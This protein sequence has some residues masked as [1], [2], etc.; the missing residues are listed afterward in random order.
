M[1]ISMAS[2]FAA[3]VMAC[4]PALAADMSLG[5]TPDTRVRKSVTRSGTRT[6]VSTGATPFT[7]PLAEAGREIYEAAMDA[8]KESCLW[9]CPTA[10]TCST[11]RVST[12]GCWKAR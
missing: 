4:A 2:L 11:Q 5:R 10:I 12:P 3:L 8:D 6:K 9:S 7:V 1:Q